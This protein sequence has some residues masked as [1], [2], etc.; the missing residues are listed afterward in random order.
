MDHILNFFVE[1]V[2]GQR[3]WPL[4]L[5]MLLLPLFGL[6]RGYY[7]LSFRLTFSHP[8]F[9]IA[10]GVIV[11]SAGFLYIRV[12][13]RGLRTRSRT[14]LGV[15]LE[16]LAI[17]L[18]SG[19]YVSIRGRSLPGDSIVIGIAEFTPIS[20]GAAEASLNLRDRIE[21]KL[22]S[23]AKAGVPLVVK[24]LDGTVRGE[25]MAGRARVARSLGHDVHLV[26]WGEVRFDEGELKFRPHLT[27]VNQSPRAR[28]SERSENLQDFA[29]IAPKQLP[30]KELV[31]DSLAGLITTVYGIASFEAGDY[32]RAISILKHVRSREAYLFTGIAA[33]MRASYSPNPSLDYALA[34]ESLNA[35]LRGERVASDR[36]S[37]GLTML[38]WLNRAVIINHIAEHNPQAGAVLLPEAATI[39]REALT[40]IPRE[41][42]AV[43]WSQTKKNL[44]DTYRAAS[45]GMPDG[46]SANSLLALAIDEYTEALSVIGRNRRHILYAAL[47]NSLGTTLHAKSEYE[48]TEVARQSLQTAIDHFD[49][50]AKS[51]RV[52]G[53]R[54][55]WAAAQSNR[56]G[57]LRRL[58]AVSDSTEAISHLHRAKRAANAS[59]AV[60]GKKDDPQGW[61]MAQ[62]NLGN[63]LAALGTYQTGEEANQT[64]REAIQAYDRALEV[65]TRSLSPWEWARVQTNRANA[66]TQLGARLKTPQG[67]VLLVN[68]VGDFEQVLTV[69]TKERSPQ[70]WAATQANMGTALSHLAVW[71]PQRE[72]HQRRVR[73]LAAYDAALQVYTRENFPGYWKQLTAARAS[74][75][76]QIVGREVLGYEDVIFFSP[77]CPQTEPGNPHKNWCVGR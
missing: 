50:A 21:E 72:G 39:F 41:K 58:A 17:V 20:L 34:L 8:A 33:G 47:R 73:A 3:R 30:F 6:V 46:K 68:A 74:V 38:A 4:F 69:R 13:P 67:V 70:Q 43:F 51:W 59:L 71:S 1:W 31:S 66:V 28:F 53:N 63:I 36:S 23:L 7:S 5:L 44:G 22:D 77:L 40:R 61:S 11:I 45:P 9:L 65:H 64:L 32:S 29:S 37:N 62:G 15:G 27:I 56:A 35:A 54:A 26:L 14:L 60:R 52:Q 55:S 25:D 2:R 42:N 18:F 75:M 49:E 48:S 76:S 10:S 12:V 24:R 16:I 19:A 57:T